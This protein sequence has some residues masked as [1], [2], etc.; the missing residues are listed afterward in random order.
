[1]CLPVHGTVGHQ[2]ASSPSA[3]SQLSADKHLDLLTNSGRQS[4][5]YDP[6]PTPVYSSVGFDILG[7]LVENVNGKSYSEYLQD[8]V[9]QTAKLNRTSVEIPGDQSIGFIPAVPGCSGAMYS[10]NNDILSFRASI[11][12]SE[13]FTLERTRAWLKPR[14]STSSSGPY[15]GGPWEVARGANLASDGRNIDFYTKTGNQ[16]DYTNVLVLVPDYDLVIAINLV[17]GV[18]SSLPEIE[19]LFSALVK[20]LIPVVD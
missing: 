12:S 6:F 8:S 18:H 16:Y 1:M 4:R 11:L 2:L 3:D 7:K 14:S 17:G 13:L 5:V 19:A 9:F 10:S 20:A 15:V